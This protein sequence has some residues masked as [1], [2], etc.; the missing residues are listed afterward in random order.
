MRSVTIPAFVALFSVMVAVP[1]WA[2]GDVRHGAVVFGQCALC[3]NAEKGGG[4]GMG[5]NLFG[6]VGRKA[7][8]VPGFPYSPALKN[9]KIVWTDAELRRWVAAPQQ[10]VP[11]SRMF[12]A[13]LHDQKDVD[14]LIAYLKTRK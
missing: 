1:G 4:N 9:S 12:F 8:S 2:V 6:I 5:P 10:L 3:H 11:G 14:D 7:A 13:G